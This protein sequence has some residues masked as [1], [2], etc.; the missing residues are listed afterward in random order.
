M[1][2][3]GPMAMEVRNN[4]VEPLRSAAMLVHP[5]EAAGRLQR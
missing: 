3:F 2:N 1:S 4:T 5:F